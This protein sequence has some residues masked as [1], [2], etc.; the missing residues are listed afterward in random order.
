MVDGLRIT[1]SLE[2]HLRRESRTRIFKNVQ[3]VAINDK[4]DEFHALEKV[5]A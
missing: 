2:R 1:E 5:H 4:K 3:I